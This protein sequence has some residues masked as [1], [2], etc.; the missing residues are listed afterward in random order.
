[1]IIPTPVSSSRIIPVI[2]S[3]THKWIFLSSQVMVGHLSDLTYV[4]LTRITNK[5]DNL[6]VKEDYEIWA[7]TF[8]VK[9]NRYH[10]ENVIFSKQ[11]FG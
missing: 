10:A 1:M 9:I 3:Q 2:L 11:P 6:A 4:H 8:G 7:D 5:E